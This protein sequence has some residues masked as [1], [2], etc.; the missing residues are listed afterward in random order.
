[1]ANN[2]CRGSCLSWGRDMAKNE[3]IINEASNPGVVRGGHEASMH[4]F[5]RSREVG[6]TGLPHFANI[7]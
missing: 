4:S 1:M 7:A 6:G 5:Q 3:P 2:N